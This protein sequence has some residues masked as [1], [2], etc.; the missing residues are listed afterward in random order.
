MSVFLKIILTILIVMGSFPEAIAQLTLSAQ[1]RPRL[2]YRDGF[3]IPKGTNSEVAFFVSQR[4]RLNIRFENEKMELFISPQDIRVWGMEKQMGQVPNFGLHE[5]W[6]RLK[7]SDVFSVKAGRQEFVYD[8]HRLLGNV[9][10]AQ[11]ARSHDALLFEYEKNG[12]TLDFGGAFNQSR[13]QVFTTF[14]RPDNYKVL[15]LIHAEKK[16]DKFSWSGIMVSDAFEKNDSIHDL[17]WRYTVGTLLSYKVSKLNLEGSIYGQGGETRSGQRIAAYMFTAKVLYKF[18]KFSLATG[19]D[20]IS[21]NNPDDQKFQAFNTLYATNHKFY[22][23]MD[24]FLN[25]PV[26][27]DGGG[28]QDYYLSAN[29]S[30][31]SKS[32]IKF[33]YHQFLSAAAVYDAEKPGKFLDKNLGREIDVVFE[34]KIASYAKFNIGLS[35]YSPTASTQQIR[36]GSEDEISTW[37]WMML[38]LSPELFSSEK[39]K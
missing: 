36:G 26:D 1:V 4:T 33:A 27:A 10:W 34:N 18:N 5:A 19:L 8:G 21:G 14:Y 30:T 2:E 17:F 35:F 31:G 12:F 25:I 24:Y 11:Q 22:G 38:A 3:R 28:L 20:F 6:G 23:F 29:V 16:S 13:E 39:K 15:T 7:F 9:D 32:S 37:G